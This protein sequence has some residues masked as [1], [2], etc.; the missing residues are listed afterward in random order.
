MDLPEVTALVIDPSVIKYKKELDVLHSCWELGE[1]CKARVTI[2]GHVVFNIDSKS[3]LQYTASY[4][5][6]GM[7]Y[8]LRPGKRFIPLYLYCDLAL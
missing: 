1:S 8:A 5:T 2:D 3:K 6:I 4:K 7:I